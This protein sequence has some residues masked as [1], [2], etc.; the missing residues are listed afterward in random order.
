[1]TI[2]IT[3]TN[4]TPVVTADTIGVTEDAVDQSG[5]NDG[6]VNT[7]IV[8]GNVLSNDSDVDTG[9]VIRVT[10]VAAGTPPSTSGSVAASVERTGA[11]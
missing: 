1:M 10:S 8:A 7:T 6:D 3:G 5:Y 4:G 9:D 2:T 11:W